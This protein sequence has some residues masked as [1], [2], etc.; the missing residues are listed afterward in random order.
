MAYGVRRGHVEEFR[1]KKRGEHFEQSCL[2]SGVFFRNQKECRNNSSKNHLYISEKEL[3]NTTRRTSAKSENSDTHRNESLT[4]LDRVPILSRRRSRI[5][6]VG[7]LHEGHGPQCKKCM[8]TPDPRY[9]PAGTW[10]LPTPQIFVQVHETQVFGCLRLKG[11]STSIIKL[12]S[13]YRGT[14]KKEFTDYR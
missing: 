14:R 7:F 13:V 9:F 6:W 10:I 3:P 1:A 12:E 5:Q 8:G 4:I 11:A 2:C